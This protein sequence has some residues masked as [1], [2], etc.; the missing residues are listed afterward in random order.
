[1]F[2]IKSAYNIPAVT[3]DGNNVIGVYEET[4]KAIDY[5]RSGKGPYFLECVTYRW[6]GHS[7]SDPCAYRP[8]GE[9]EEWIKK[10]PI[11]KLEADLISNNVDIKDLEKIKEDV[12][13]QILEAIEFGRKG[14][15]P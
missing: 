12:N 8:L 6:E 9:K 7:R 4:K 10:C 14:P 13:E 11:K 1:M 5:A 2:E 3:I 15:D